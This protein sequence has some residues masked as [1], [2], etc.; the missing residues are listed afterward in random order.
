MK[1]RR[2]Q[3]RKKKFLGTMDLFE[4]KLSEL[5]EV[6]QRCRFLSAFMA[7]LDVDTVNYHI[8]SLPLALHYQCTGA[9]YWYK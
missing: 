2:R 9:K 7:G 3:I 1:Q 8:T 5:V 6:L 4:E